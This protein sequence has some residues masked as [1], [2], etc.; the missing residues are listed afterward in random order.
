M[1]NTHLTDTS[2][3]E[4]CCPCRGGIKEKKKKKK[5]FQI[6]TKHRIEKV[7]LFWYTG[8]WSYRFFYNSHSQNL[9]PEETI[10]SHMLA[11]STPQT[12]KS[13]TVIPALRQITW[14]WLKQDWKSCFGNI[15]GESTTPQSF[16]WLFQHLITHS[17]LDTLYLACNMNQFSFSSQWLFFSPFSAGLKW[18]FTRGEIIYCNQVIS[19]LNLL[20]V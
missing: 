9:K 2:I 12:I 10:R 1:F 5:P 15:N 11:S 3:W 8:T 4:Q 14:M 19:R 16:N 18:F 13:Y 6:W 17:P 20:I 7:I